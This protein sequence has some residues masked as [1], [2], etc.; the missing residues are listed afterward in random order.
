MH[1]SAPEGEFAGNDGTD[2]AADPDGPDPE[3]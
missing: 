1:R 2:A 3:A